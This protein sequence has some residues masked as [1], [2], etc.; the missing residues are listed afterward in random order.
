MTQL[1]L[2][3][4]WK[5]FAVILKKQHNKIFLLSGYTIATLLAFYLPWAFS[6]IASQTSVYPFLN[7]LSV[8]YLSVLKGLAN[9][10]QVLNSSNTFL[11][12]LSFVKRNT[13]YSNW[14]INWWIFRV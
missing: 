14:S 2:V 6:S 10:G 9:S 1:F 4:L 3:F 8:F 13:I 11:Y 7:P 5:L 12:W